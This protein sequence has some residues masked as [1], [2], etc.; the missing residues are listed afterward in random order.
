MRIVEAGWF[1]SSEDG[2]K[3]VVNAGDDLDPGR[4]SFFP[5]WGP[6]GDEAKEER[7]SDL[8]ALLK[9]ETSIE[10]RNERYRER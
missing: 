2:R 5:P 9:S 8:C 1:R 7:V 3:F 10:I 6:R 4:K